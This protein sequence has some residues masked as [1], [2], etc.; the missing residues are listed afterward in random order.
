MLSEDKPRNESANR[1]PRG[2]RCEDIFGVGRQTLQED[3]RIYRQIPAYAQTQA[4]VQNTQSIPY[5]NKKTAR[6]SQ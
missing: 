5:V 6:S 2:Q 4:G 3:G 1:P